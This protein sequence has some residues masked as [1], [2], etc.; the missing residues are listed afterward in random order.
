MAQIFSRHEPHPVPAPHA[1]PI[2]ASVVAPAEIAWDTSA[3][4]TAWQIHAYTQ[5]SEWQLT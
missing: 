5:S 2:S 4:E 3:S 1:C